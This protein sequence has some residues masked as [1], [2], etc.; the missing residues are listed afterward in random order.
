MGTFGGTE[1]PGQRQQSDHRLAQLQHSISAILGGYDIGQYGF[2]WQPAEYQVYDSPPGG[3][4]VP[5]SH[6]SAAKLPVYLVH[7]GGH[8]D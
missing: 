7:S 4:R 1:L 2:G 3:K 6:D 5:D 8:Q